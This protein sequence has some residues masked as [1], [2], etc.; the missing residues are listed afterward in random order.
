MFE[1]DSRYPSIKELVFDAVRQT[2]GFVDF[3]TITS[4]VRS[5][6]PKSKW[7]GTHWSWYRNQITMGRF[8]NL[9]SEEIRNNLR[10]T[11]KQRETHS[12]ENRVKPIGDA[13]LKH[14]RS[15]MNT[16]CGEEQ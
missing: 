5:A 15:V 12:S 7:D 11:T 1:Q 4:Q 8:K 13:I 10:T 2:K 3:Q 9:F 14:A 6:F 16:E